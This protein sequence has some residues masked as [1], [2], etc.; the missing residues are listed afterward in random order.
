MSEL[1]RYAYK[2]LGDG[3]SDIVPDPIGNWVEWNDV[4]NML[5]ILHKIHNRAEVLCFKVDDLFHEN[6]CNLEPKPDSC[7]RCFYCLVESNRSRCNACCI[8]KISRFKPTNK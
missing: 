3:E 8:E 1:K 5:T 6:V 4:V 2:Y 7:D